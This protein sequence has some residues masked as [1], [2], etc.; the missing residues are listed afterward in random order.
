MPTTIDWLIDCFVCF[1]GLQGGMEE[2]GSRVPAR[3]RRGSGA[4]ESKG[5]GDESEREQEADARRVQPQS[6][7]AQRSAGEGPFRFAAVRNPFLSL[8]LNSESID[9]IFNVSFRS[10]SAEEARRVQLETRLSAV[11]NDIAR[12]KQEIANGQ[13]ALEEGAAVFEALKI[14][15]QQ[16]VCPL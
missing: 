4:E 6:G 9:L 12:L 1:F 8:L 7:A 5:K 10:S 11:G 15:H 14:K 13:K 2:G 3:R 16:N